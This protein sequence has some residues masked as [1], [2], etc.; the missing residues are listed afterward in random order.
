MDAEKYDK[1]QEITKS[2][3]THIKSHRNSRKGVRRNQVQ[4][5]EQ[6]E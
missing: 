3:L 2:D 5:E 6:E 4:A 1:K